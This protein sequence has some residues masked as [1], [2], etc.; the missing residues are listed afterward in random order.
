MKG[1]VELVNAGRADKPG[2]TRHGEFRVR[3]AQIKRK[4]R[5]GCL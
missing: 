4:N 1:A 2:E 5:K 3:L